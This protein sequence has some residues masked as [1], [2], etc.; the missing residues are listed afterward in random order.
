MISLNH[1]DTSLKWAILL[2]RKKKVS[3]ALAREDEILNKMNA[4]RSNDL[5]KL[6]LA[7][8]S[9]KS[10]HLQPQISYAL[11]YKDISLSC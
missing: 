5:P 6:I 2:W 8:T 7:L 10:T 9:L 4:G 1:S 3:D 11:Y